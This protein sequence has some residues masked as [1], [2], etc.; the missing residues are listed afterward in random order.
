MAF[1]QA[2]GLGFQLLLLGKEVCFSRGNV[3]PGSGEK[4]GG[5][6]RWTQRAAAQQ[7]NGES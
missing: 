1:V 2:A 6:L 3:G 5:R 7:E 4:Y